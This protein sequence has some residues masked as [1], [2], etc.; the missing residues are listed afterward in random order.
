[1]LLLMQNML[2]LENIEKTQLPC[3]CGSAP[4]SFPCARLR[5]ANEIPPPSCGGISPN[6]KFLRLGSQ[7]LCRNVQKPEEFCMCDWPLGPFGTAPSG[8]SSARCPTKNRLEYTWVCAHFYETSRKRCVFIGR[9]AE[10]FP[11][12]MLSV[13]KR[14]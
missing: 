11:T 9:S 6:W 8:N 14:H 7:P 4:M 5:F 3:R 12:W 1:M 2:M 10:E 13:L